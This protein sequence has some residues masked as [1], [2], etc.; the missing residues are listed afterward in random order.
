M[1]VRVAGHFGEWLQG[2]LGA[3]GPVVLLTVACPALY[4]EAMRTGDG[5]VA[6]S[7]SP[8][9][10]SPARARDFLRRTRGRS[11]RYRLT[12]NM[13]PGGGAGAST[14]A[15]VALARAA[16][17]DPARLIEACL[18]VEGASDPLMLSQ[19]DRVLWASR[20][21]RGVADTPALPRAEII[22]GFW[23]APTAT[24]PAD[25][26]FPDVSDLARRVKPGLSLPELAGIASLSAQRSTDMRGPK[27]DPTKALARD[28]GALGHVRA[29][30]GSARGLIF[31][32]GTVPGGAEQALEKA[33]YQGILRFETGGK[34]R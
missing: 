23:G 13:P 25:T 8:V 20:E 18:A 21:G 33:G 32:P 17:G 28:L 11:A 27:A 9:L 4:V 24:D 3:T 16:Q 29:H 6:L 12:T 30:T 26:E 10:V 15:L 34:P 14:A 5:P 1:S 7:Q 2:R 22:G 19:P 31:V